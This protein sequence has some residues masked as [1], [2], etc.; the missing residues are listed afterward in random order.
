MKIRSSEPRRV[1]ARNVPFYTALYAV[2]GT[3]MR[4]QVHTQ[5][6]CRTQALYVRSS[7]RTVPGRPVV[8]LGV[9]YTLCTNFTQGVVPV[10]FGSRVHHGTII[11]HMANEA[12]GE[13]ARPWNGN[14]RSTV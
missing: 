8:E 5:V 11:I 4:E 10:R 14:A 12:C 1:G 3:G 9:Y 2:Q 13:A 7:Y 6:S